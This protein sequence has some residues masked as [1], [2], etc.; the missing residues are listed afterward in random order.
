MRHIVILSPR[1]VSFFHS[2]LV[3]R[4]KKNRSIKW[5]GEEEAIKR[6]RPTGG[7]EWEI[8]L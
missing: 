6:F 1:V 7:L 2:S 5:G 4:A 8:E 3:K